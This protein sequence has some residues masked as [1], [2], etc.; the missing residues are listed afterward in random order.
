MGDTYVISGLTAKRAELAGEI[1]QTE[2]HLAGLRSAL[3]ALDLTIGLFDPSIAPKA[4]RPKLKRIA[5]DGQF[6]AGELTRTVLGVLRRANRP[7]T[8]R[9][10][11]GEVAA[12]CGLDMSTIAAANVVVANTRAALSRPHD[13]LMSKKEGR[14][15]MVYWVDAV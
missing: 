8:V 1:Q 13:G 3:E 7:L 10:I 14:E 2:K 12:I 9:E 4:I 11:A 6:K 5:K 15:P